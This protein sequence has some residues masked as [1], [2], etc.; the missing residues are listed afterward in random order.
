ML[1]ALNTAAL[2]MNA[3]QRNVDNIANNMANAST[4]GYKQTRLVFQDLIYQNIQAGG[5]NE[6]EGN[7]APSMLQIGHGATPIASVRD[8]RPGGLK[9][10]G[11]SLDLAINGDGFLQIQRP[12]G[13]IAYTRDG[14]FSLDGDGNI[15]THSGLMLE[16]NLNV[17]PEATSI[18][19]SQDGVVTAEFEGDPMGMELG[20]IELARFTNPEGLEPKGGNLF[21]ETMASGP[22]TLA[23]PGQDGMGLVRQGFL[24]TSNV[25]I[26]REMV[27]LIEAQRAYEVNSKMITT[28][29]DMLQVANNLKR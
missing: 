3:Q 10:T 12:D 2:G 27:S 9:E 25:D 15:V 21:E 5:Q 26:V 19:I 16:P 23:T 18:R 4:T 11:N 1:R 20:Q 8:F 7:E 14:N 17:P 28:T 6:A 22:P 29:E 13:S 24:E